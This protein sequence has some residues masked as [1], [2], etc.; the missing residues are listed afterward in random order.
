M[1]E[2]EKNR[3]RVTGFEY[4]EIPADG[5]RGSFYLDCYSS[6]GWVM[7]ERAQPHRGKAVLRRSRNIVNKMELTRLQR[8]FES[9][10]EEIGALERSKTSKATVAALVIALIGCA[11]LAGSVFAVTHEPPLILLTVLLAIP[12]FL[13]WILPYF[14]YRRMAA[15]RAKVVNELME[16]KYDEICELCEKGSQLLT[17]L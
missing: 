2:I 17:G 11:F 8:H 9:C 6:F 16:Q 12:G 13:G 4:K 7:D 15:S 3:A 5:E 1:G 10:L 14:V